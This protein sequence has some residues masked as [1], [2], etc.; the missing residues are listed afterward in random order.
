M[1]RTKF[2]PM[3]LLLLVLLTS[4]STR[5]EAPFESGT[6]GVRLEVLTDLAATRADAEGQFGPEDFRIEVINPEGIIFK[7]WNTYAEYLAQ[8]NTVFTMNAGGPYTL[9]ATYGD[10]TASGF[11]AFFFI[12]EQEFTVLQQ[13]VTDVSV[14]CRMGN[15]KVAVEY[16]DNIRKNYADY[17]AT[18]STSR[19]SIVFDKECAEAG[20]LPCGKLS[21]HVEA[22]SHEG[23]TTAFVNSQEIEGNPGDFITLKI[24]SGEIPES[25]LSLT[26]S[27]DAATDDHQINIELPSDMLPADAPLIVSDGFDP[28]TGNLSGFIEGVAPAKA[29]LTLN[30]P[31][32]MVSCLLGIQSRAL[33]EAGWPAEIDLLNPTSEQSALLAD[34]G[35]MAV[36]GRSRQSSVV[37]DFTTLAG[38]LAWAEDSEAN[39]SA[40][41]LMI[42]DATGR[43]VS[44]TYRIIPS[45]ASSVISAIPEG[46]VWAVRVYAD[47]T[48]D[49]NPALLYPEVR[50]EGSEEWIR[51]SFTA[52]VSGQTSRVTVTGLEPSVRYAIRAGYNAHASA[53][54]Q[55]FTTEAAL[56]P[57]NAGF[58]EWTTQT[59]SFVYSFLFVNESHD[60]NWDLPWTGEQWW[61]VNSKRTMPSSTSVVSANWN[62][63]RFPTVAYTTDAYEGSRAAMV[64]SVNVGDWVTDA[65]LVGSRV[66]GELFIGT[67]DDSGNHSSDGHAFASRPSAL[68]FYYKYLPKDSET[69]YAKVDIRSG[70]NVIASKEISDGGSASEWTVMELPLEYGD[71]SQKATSVYVSF[72]STTAENP[73]VTGNY[74]LSIRDK[75]TYTGNFGSILYIDKLEFIYE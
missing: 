37:L 13:E 28:V 6:G 46:D 25:D 30:V 8:E 5:E 43:T 34:Y 35:L 56:Q 22:V 61:A 72:K 27:I 65:A 31:T 52:S 59:H 36:S 4:C 39:I 57:G 54:E 38:R 20:Y 64:Y 10:S 18:V 15:V 3:Y 73:A 47:L 70:D 21:V 48:T 66:A 44:E 9:R 17:T 14:I 29:S 24:D 71:T 1:S 7:R 74:S 63:V 58:E 41:T 67:A 16:G 2:F 40:F 69:F 55:E 51:P 12:G 53:T 62:W 23:D 49:G 60:I 32:G 26:V 68:R 19:G 33:E 42:A 50:A 45:K 75:E 11:N